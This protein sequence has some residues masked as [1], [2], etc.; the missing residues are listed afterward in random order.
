[1]QGDLSFLLFSQ[2]HEIKCVL[3]WM[4]VLVNRQ[5]QPYVGFIFQKTDKEVD[6]F[7]GIRLADGYTVTNSE[8]LC[9]ATKVSDNTRR[10]LILDYSNGDENYVDLVLAIR[11]RDLNV[12]QKPLGD[13]TYGDAVESDSWF[14]ISTFLDHGINNTDPTTIRL[15]AD[16]KLAIPVYFPS[17]AMDVGFIV[18][19]DGAGAGAGTISSWLV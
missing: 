9:G 2:L 6:M 8:N 14:N 16:A 12:K 10:W 17:G 7:R 15:D 13:G 19:A 4:R 3:V 5:D 11:H 18:T 1:M